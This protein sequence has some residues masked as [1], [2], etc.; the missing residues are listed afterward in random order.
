MFPDYKG[1]ENTETDSCS[2]KASNVARSLLFS[3]F[4]TG[5]FLDLHFTS[6]HFTSHCAPRPVVTHSLP[7]NTETIKVDREV[8][9]ETSCQ[10]ATMKYLMLSCGADILNSVMLHRFVLP[11]YKILL[12][13]SSQCCLRYGYFSL[14]CFCQKEIFHL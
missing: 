14:S 10:P 13:V 2:F 5:K 1:N 3:S 9:S 11:F 4:S 6:L 8:C 7:E 12:L